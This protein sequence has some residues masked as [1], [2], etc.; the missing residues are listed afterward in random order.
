MRG[1]NKVLLTNI[2]VL[3]LKCLNFVLNLKVFF[4]ISSLKHSRLS[5]L[6]LTKDVSIIIGIALKKQTRILKIKLD[7]TSLKKYSHIYFGHVKPLPC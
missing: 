4:L 7:D 6:Q 3:V 5:L 1:I 2:I